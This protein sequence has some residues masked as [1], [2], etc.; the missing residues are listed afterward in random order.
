MNSTKELIQ[1]YDVTKNLLIIEFTFNSFFFKSHLE[2]E[3]NLL[4]RKLLSYELSSTY[5]SNLF[6]FN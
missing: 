1:K 6:I 2:K 3:N 4:Q 5:S